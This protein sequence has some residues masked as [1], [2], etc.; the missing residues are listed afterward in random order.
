MTQLIAAIVAGVFICLGLVHVYWASGGR[1]A[2]L[3]AIPE[4]NERPAFTPRRWMTFCV[5][6]ALFTAALL[7]A[8]T[9]RLI[10][11][12]AAHAGARALTFVLGAVLIGRAIGDFR[13]VGLFKRVRGTRF[14][15]LD[16]AL[17]APLCAV[18]GGAALWIACVNR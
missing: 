17:Y 1:I 11:S 8:L 7:V 6:L 14:A 12:P 2:W 5:A 3:A 10:A 9:A 13:L 15:R 18:L 4:V 16:T